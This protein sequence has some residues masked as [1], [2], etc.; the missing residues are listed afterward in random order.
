MAGLQTA[1]AAGTDN[2]PGGSFSL[3]FKLRSQ[4]PSEGTRPCAAL[5][6][7]CVPS[8]VGGLLLALLLASLLRRLL[9]SFLLGHSTS[10]VKT[11]SS[12]QLRSRR[13]LASRSPLT[14]GSRSLRKSDCARPGEHSVCRRIFAR[15]QLSTPLVSV[16][17]ASL[18]LRRCNSPVH[19]RDRTKS[20]KRANNRQEEIH[21][22][23]RT[24]ENIFRVEKARERRFTT[25]AGRPRRPSAGASRSSTARASRTSA[26][27]TSAASRVRR[28]R[29]SR[30]R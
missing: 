1:R 24:G 14:V 17:T 12:G 4:R 13:T 20:S 10:S 19:D 5:D 7:C 21:E 29:P 8:L 27:Q 30:R 15:E 18:G 28:P 25:V 11:E 2:R 9:R 16:A 3:F 26:S 23:A 6:R 22:C